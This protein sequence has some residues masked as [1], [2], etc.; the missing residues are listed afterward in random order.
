MSQEAR[1]EDFESLQKRVCFINEVYH[2]SALIEEF[3]RGTEFTVP[4]IGN[5]PPEAMPVVQISIDGTVELGDKFYS[6]ERI[7][8]PE[9]KYVCP[10]QIPQGLT[11]QLQQLARRVFESVGCRDMGRVDF[12]VDEKG[13]PFVLEINP[14]PYLGHED[15]FNFFPKVLG[16]TYE[17]IINRILD[18]ALKRYGLYEPENVMLKS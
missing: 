7:T 15:V 13:Q 1:V 10:A 5:D 16:T 8:S 6:F 17:E 18:C 11:Q 2:Q 9:L 12:R 4:V 3:I 14:L